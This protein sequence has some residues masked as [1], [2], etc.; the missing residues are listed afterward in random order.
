M[1]SVDCC[2]QVKRESTWQHPLLTYYQG[3][4]FMAMGGSAAV[5]KAE[6]TKPCTDAEVCNVLP[7]FILQICIPCL[8]ASIKHSPPR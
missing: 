7:P 4:V 6:A 2:V 1:M 3:A 8:L 5:A